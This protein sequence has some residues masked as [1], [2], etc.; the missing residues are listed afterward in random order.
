M[1]CWSCTLRTPAAPRWLPMP[2]HA[3]LDRVFHRQRLASSEVAF[4]VRSLCQQNALPTKHAASSR[5]PTA[6]RHPT[7]QA[8]PREIDAAKCIP[9]RFFDINPIYIQSIFFSH[10]SRT[11]VPRSPYTDPIHSPVQTTTRAQYP[12]KQ[13]KPAHPKYKVLAFTN[14]SR[15]DGCDRHDHRPEEGRRLLRLSPQ[16]P[17]RP[18]TRA[19]PVPVPEHAGD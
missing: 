15:R 17:G 19:S 11:T 9:P 16:P 3:P 13:G 10:K 14:G 12:H 8:W 1:W 2:D 4:N 18:S 6:Y 5:I 7:P